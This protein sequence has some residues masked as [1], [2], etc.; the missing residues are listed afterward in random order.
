MSIK[1]EVCLSGI[2]SAIAAQKGG[3]NRVELCGCLSVGGTTPS[4]GTIELVRQHI[5]IDLYVMI[6]P[7]RGDFAYSAY[8]FEEMKRDIEAAKESGAQGVVFGILKPN[9]MVDK[10][11]AGELL[12]LARP[13]GVTFHRAFD[14]T[15]DPF[16]ALEDLIELGIDRVLTSGQADSAL[17]GQELLAELVKQADDRIIMMAGVGIT[18]NNVRQ[19]IRGSGVKEIHVRSGCSQVI[20]SVMQFRNPAIPMGGAPEL[21]EYVIRQTSAERVRS[22]VQAVSSF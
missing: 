11:R 2:E 7:R 3:A 21:S 4:R 8:E 5:D 13:M 18:E 19:I 12:A 14:M 22:I 9:G 1:V 6:R 17:A 20:E 15:R 10:R 16:E